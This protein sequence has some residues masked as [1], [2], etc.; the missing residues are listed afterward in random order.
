MRIPFRSLLVSSFVIALAVSPVI[1]QG[2]A[3]DIVEKHLAA[4]GG[5]EAL[6]KLTSRRASATVSISTPAGDLTG[7]AE[8]LSKAPN[9][10]RVTIELDLTPV[11]VADKMNIEQKF[12]GTAGWAI[13]SMQGDTEI[14]GSQL[15][16]MKNN[17]FPTPLLVYKT[18][19]GKVETQPRED[20][21]GKS[22]HVILYTPKSGS[23]ARMYFDPD[24]YL[25]AR[26][27]MTVN[28]PQLGG[29]VE[30]VGDLS[31]YRT[32]DGIKVPFMIVNAN[33]QQT[34]TIKLG[35]VEHNVEIADAVFS[36]KAP[37]YLGA[38]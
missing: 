32:V 17:F 34:I 16:N 2:T 10:A 5:R 28:V 30:Q 23:P 8:M 9:K 37:A 29:D 19:G 38:R 20:V 4:L 22:M 13:N 1:G 7:P 27:R 31:D 11:G 26:T 24:T 3:D 25:L 12:D 21:G 14:T 18:S 6:T 35:K 15:E 33:P 36:V